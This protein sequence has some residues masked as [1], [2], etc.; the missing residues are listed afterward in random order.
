MSILPGEGWEYEISLNVSKD[1]CFRKM[2][3][4]QCYKI[5]V[6]NGF[7]NHSIKKLI[8]SENEATC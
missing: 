8:V 5:H 4:S 3:M 1:K 7:R 6:N 2:V